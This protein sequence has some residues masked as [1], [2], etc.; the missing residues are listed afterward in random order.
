MTKYHKLHDSIF[1]EKTKGFFV[2]CIEITGENYFKIT[3]RDEQS[4]DKF[5]KVTHVLIAFNSGESKLDFHL[6]KDNATVTDF[7]LSG[8]DA[9]GALTKFS[10]SGL[11]SKPLLKEITNK[12]QT[13]ENKDG[14]MGCTVS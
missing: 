3:C 10:E 8:R 5:D 7:H 9:Y 13:V 14:M 12:N 1:S 4:A 6:K 2:Q 11:L